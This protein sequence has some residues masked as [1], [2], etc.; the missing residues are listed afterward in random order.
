M[1]F[2]G[3]PTFRGRV[4]RSL[5]ERRSKTVESG[6]PSEAET[7]AAEAVG[8]GAERPGLIGPFVRQA[9]FP[10]VDARVVSQFEL[11]LRGIAVVSDEGAAPPKC[12]NWSG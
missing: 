9:P 2:G 1:S 8:C 10:S 11:P 4:E 12:Q 3:K 7:S 5:L 6:A